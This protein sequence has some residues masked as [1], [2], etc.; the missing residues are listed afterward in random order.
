MFPITEY[1]FQMFDEQNVA[2]NKTTDSRVSVHC[3]KGGNVCQDNLLALYPSV[4]HPNVRFYVKVALDKLFEGIIESMKF[5]MYTSNP[6]YTFYL[7]GLRYSLLLVSIIG[8]ISYFFFFKNLQPSN[9]TFEHKYILVLSIALIA[10]NDPFYALTVFHNSPQLTTLS[11]IS[12]SLFISL[13]LF[14]WMVMFPRIN[15][16]HN[17]ISTGFASVMTIAVAFVLFIFL[18]MLLLIHSVYSRYNPS[19]HWEVK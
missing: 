4:T 8:L 6:E 10:L 17:K 14:F 16:E 1:G 13:L 12:V 5:Y 7:L 11:T 3:E 9:R 19:I 2:H 15:Y 18:T